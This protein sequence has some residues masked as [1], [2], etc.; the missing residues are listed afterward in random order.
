VRNDSIFSGIGVRA[1]SDLTALPSENVLSAYGRGLDIDVQ[2]IREHLQ[3]VTFRQILHVKLDVE[4]RQNVLDVVRQLQSLEGIRYVGP[5]M[6]Y[7]DLTVNPNNTYFR[8]GTQ[9]ALNGVN[10]INAPGAWGITPGSRNVR[11]G[12]IDSGIARHDNLNANVDFNSGGDFVNMI[13]IPNNL[14]GPLRPD[15]NGHGTS[16]ASVVGAVGNIGIGVTGVAQ[17]VTMVPMQTR[18]VAPFHSVDAMIRAVTYARNSWNTNQR[19]SVLNMSIGGFGANVALRDSIVHFPGLFVWSA[20]NDGRD[21]DDTNRFPNMR[22]FKPPYANNI[23]SVGA[24][25]RNGGRSNWHEC[26]IGCS[27]FGLMCNVVSESNFGRNSVD[28]FA[29]GGHRGSSNQNIRVAHL[30]NG[31]S[32]YLG[33][34]SSAPHVAGV[35]AL[36]L[37]VNPHLSA[38]R[39][40]DIIIA[41][42]DRNSDLMNRSV[43]GGRLNAYGAV[44]MARDSQFDGNILWHQPEFRHTNHIPGVGSVNDT[45][46]FDGRSYT[47]TSLVNE[48]RNPRQQSVTLQLESPIVVQRIEVQAR[49]NLLGSGIGSARRSHFYIYFDGSR[50]GNAVDVHRDRETTMFSRNINGNR[51]T[52]VNFLMTAVGASVHIYQI[53]IIALQ[54]IPAGMQIWQQP[55]W[56]SPSNGQ[57]SLNVNYHFS[58]FNWNDGNMDNAVGL[59]GHGIPIVTTWQGNVGLYNDLQI[60]LSNRMRIKYIEIVARATNQGGTGGATRLLGTIDWAWSGWH[61]VPH[62]NTVRTF[63]FHHHGRESNLARMIW[64][65]ER[66]QIVIYEM[67]VFAVVI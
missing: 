46:P 31:F 16:S 35:A 67:R 56:T 6:Y 49:A 62:D 63:R 64:R 3:D 15:D 13:S 37:S 18:T 54:P 36:M 66:S 29:P 8:N 43:A 65:T 53:R 10:G 25:N 50:D 21:M 5:N 30:S 12:I 51:V 32:W 27:M 28:I 20:G 11:V 24:H 1:V 9:W 4:C 34:S 57:G 33:T 47:S 58:D 17:Q 7:E 14:P 41:T 45:R 61:T 42:A 39:I 60:R 44:R 23:I 38:S 48:N 52:H 19:I 26:G 22:L 2:A 59:L 55:R 40:R